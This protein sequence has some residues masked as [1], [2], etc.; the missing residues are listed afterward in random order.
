MIDYSK[1]DFTRFQDLVIHYSISML[2]A[3]IILIGGWVLSKVIGRWTHTGLSRINGI[4]ETITGFLSNFVRYSILVMVV[5]MVLGQFGV[6]TASIIAALGAAGLAIGL[7]LQGTLQNIAAGIMLLILRPFRVGEYI[8]TGSV[9]GTVQAIGLFTTELNTIDGLYRV[10]PNSLLWNVG[11]T[12]YSRQPSRRYDLSIGIGYDDDIEM[13]LSILKSLAAD[14]ARV[15]S[16]PAPDT[17]VMELGDSAV[18]VTLRYWTKAGDFWATSRDMT[19]LAK[20]AFDKN[21][22]SI[23]F[24]QITY[25]GPLPIVEEQAE[26]TG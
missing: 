22:I 9:S 21:G 4:D 2:S 1:V 19:K 11:I 13:A 24:P 12:N 23:P 26:K 16:N 15:L 3:V 20:L 10:A 25:S 14:D 6:Q 17:F 7:A 8:E 5:V 18:V